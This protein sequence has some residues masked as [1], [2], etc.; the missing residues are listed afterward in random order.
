MPFNT[1][2]EDVR[3]S[4]LQRNDS[5]TGPMEK[6]RRKDGN[7]E[8]WETSEVSPATTPSSTRHTARGRPAVLAPL[9]PNDLKLLALDIRLARATVAVEQV[10][11]CGNPITDTYFDTSDSA[12]STQ[13]TAADKS[14]MTDGEEA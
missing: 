5:L 4:A 1:Y 11:L 6:I 10:T 9:R 3:I 2:L 7:L 8:A 13:V 14:T 12:M